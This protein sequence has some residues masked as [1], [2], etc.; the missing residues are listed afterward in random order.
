MVLP[1]GYLSSVTS[2]KVG[3][4]EREPLPAPEPLPSWSLLPCPLMP[5]PLNSVGKMAVDLNWTLAK[6]DGLQLHPDHV[7]LASSQ[8][9]ESGD[10]SYRS[11]LDFEPQTRTKHSGLCP[12]A[13]E[14]SGRETALCDLR[15]FRHCSVLHSQACP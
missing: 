1:G 11:S 12:A 3:S 6:T 14:P 2:F 15:H 8:G 5:L 7:L 10:C 4:G 13:K 9:P